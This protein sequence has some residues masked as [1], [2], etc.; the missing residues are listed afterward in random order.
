MK[1]LLIRHPQIFETLNVSNGPRIGL[2]LG[3]L[4][5]ASYIRKVYSDID[6]KVLDALIEF[7]FNMKNPIIDENG[8]IHLGM[9]YKEISEFVD[10]YRPD[11]V[12]ISNQY[13]DFLEQAFKTAEAIKKVNPHISIV[14]GGNPSTSNPERILQ[15]RNIDIVVLGEGEFT[16]AELI[17]WKRNNKK[18]PEISGIAY[19]GTNNSI[20]IN[21]NMNIINDLNVLPF[22]A[23]D[24]VDMEKY[25]QVEKMGF[26]SRYKFDYPGA[27]RT[28]S[29]ITSRGCPFQCCFCSI[30]LH[31]GKKY[32][33]NS[34][35]YVIEH[36]NHLKTIY[37]VNH[38]H[39]EDD[40]LTLNKARFHKILDGL[41]CGRNHLTWDTPNGIRID[42]LDRDLIK[43]M[44][45]TGCVYIIVG[46]ESGCQE[47]N[48]LIVKKRLNLEVAKENIKIA[49]EEGLDVH[50]FYI[51]GF[52]GETKEQIH[53]TINYAIFLKKKFFVVP[54]LGIAN[55]IEGTEM[56]E[57][58]KANGWLADSSINGIQFHFGI[59]RRFKRK[60]IKTPE[61][62]I[63]YLNH[64]LVNFQKKMRNLSIKH[65]LVLFL[66]NPFIFLYSVNYLLK[67][68][69]TEDLTISET[70]KQM[71][72]R[73]FFYKHFFLR[74][75]EH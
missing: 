48:D 22:P 55:P 71:F 44:V 53:M 66:R 49:Y 45:K 58:A 13:T 67:I 61:F 26:T 35:D 40:N 21:S 34:A 47:I 33:V 70:L 1:V 5:I 68:Y 19:R 2:P 52:P 73:K 30:K 15:D 51:I 8:F 65:V 7:S 69:A 36:I 17:E 46:I 10:S 18:L 12:G 6:V 37:N 24:L 72:L 28:I 38:I 57:I 39:F 3:I 25:F 42:T 16:M 43:K 20:V 14:I 50:A 11:I 56:F 29:I 27:E 41:E 54:H 62:D 74:N 59:E 23:Y 60:T 31:M 9:T 64:V 63:K 75:Y 4:Y 32:R